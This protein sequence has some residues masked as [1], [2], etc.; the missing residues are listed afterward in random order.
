MA[1]SVTQLAPDY[2]SP[3][4]PL[5]LTETLS[6]TKLAVVLWKHSAVSCLCVLTLCPSSPCSSFPMV[7]FRQT[8]TYCPKHCSDS[9]G[10]TYNVFPDSVSS[11]QSSNLLLMWE[12]TSVLFIFCVMALSLC[13]DFFPISFSFIRLELLENLSISVQFLSHI[14]LCDPL[15][16]SMLPCP[17]PIPRACLNSGPSSQWCHPTILS[18]VIPFSSCLQ[19]F[20]ATGSFPMSQ[21]FGITWPK[22]WSFSF[23]ISPSNE[24]SGL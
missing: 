8:P 20:P 19:S 1:N 13:S 6:T 9:A 18:S 12:A 22:Y 16:W 11:P 23:N 5:P 21:F 2:F 3:P 15:N 4:S 24:Y 7:S 14:Q 17:P 10:R